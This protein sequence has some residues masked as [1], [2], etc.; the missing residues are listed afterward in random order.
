[1]TRVGGMG[2]KGANISAAW[3]KIGFQFGGNA[4]NFAKETAHN[5]AATVQEIKGLAK[6]IL[7]LA[8]VIGGPAGM[9]L[10]QL[11]NFA[12]RMAP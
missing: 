1:M 6:T 3:E 4:S 12:L 8:N 11:G 5:T 10:N 7:I 9:G 2:S